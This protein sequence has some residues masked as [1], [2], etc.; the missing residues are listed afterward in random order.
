METIAKRHLS[1]SHKP[2]IALVVGS[3]HSGIETALQ[4]EAKERKRIISTLFKVPG[5]GKAKKHIASIARF[6]FNND[7][8]KWEVT[9][10][11]KDPNLV[12]L[13]RTK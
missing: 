2:E 13:E 6:D 7:K 1:S 3:A 8:K 4:K 10:I 11:F 9:E 5:M 12:L